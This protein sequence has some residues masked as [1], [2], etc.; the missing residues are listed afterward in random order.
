MLMLTVMHKSTKTSQYSKD[1]D[2]YIRFWVLYFNSHF[3]IMQILSP[4]NC[5]PCLLKMCLRTVYLPCLPARVATCPV[6]LRAHVVTRQRALR[7]YV[8]LGKTWENVQSIFV[9]RLYP[10][11]SCF[12]IFTSFNTT[13]PI[14]LVKIIFVRNCKPVKAD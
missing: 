13:T 12:F 10:G 6:C 5:V 4:L 3:I 11:F 8:L 1:F 9:L 7:N 2:I 14:L